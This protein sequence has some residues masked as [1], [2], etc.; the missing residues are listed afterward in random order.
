MEKDA[1]GKLVYACIPAI[2]QD[3]LAAIRH[4]SHLQV[5]F[6][7]GFIWLKGFSEGDAAKTEAKSIPYITWY[8]EEHNYLHLLGK[9]L[10]ERAIPS[11]LWSPIQRALPLK[12]DNWNHNFFGIDQKIDWQLVE[13]DEPENAV[14]LK[15]AKAQLAQFVES[16]LDFRFQHLQWLVSDEE[17]CWVLGTPL[18]PLPGETYWQNGQLFLPSGYALSPKLLANHFAKSLLRSESD[19]AIFDKYGDFFTVKSTYFKPLTRSSFRQTFQ[20]V[21]L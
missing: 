10:P 9:S 14:L 12:V 4:W 11:I 13:A 3:Y 18:L 7:D 1:S 16:A 17:Q 15:T 2:Y 5:G 19:F 20:K 6:E 21:A 8:H